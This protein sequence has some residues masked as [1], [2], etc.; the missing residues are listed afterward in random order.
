[1]S[2]GSHAPGRQAAAPDG[3]DLHALAAYLPRFIKGLQAPLEAELISGGKSNLTYYLRSGEQEWVLRRPPLGHV[4]PT[5]HDMKR[6]FRVISGLAGSGVPIPAALRLCEDVAVIGA[7]FYVMERAEGI[8]VHEELPSG[9]AERPEDRRAM[10]EAFIDTLARLHTVDYAAAGLADFGRP[11]GFMERQVRRWGEQWDRSKTRELPAIEE[12]RRRLFRSLP[13]SPAPGIVHGDYR[14]ENMI[15]DVERPGRIV[16]VLDWEMATLGDPLADLGYALM[17]WVEAGDSVERQQVMDRGAV[18]MAPGFMTR[19]EL[20]TRY[21]AVSGRT[22]R[23]VDFYTVFAHYKLAI[24]VEGI[25]ARFQ[26]GETRGEGFEGYDLKVPV[27]ADLG[28]EI[29]DRSENRALRGG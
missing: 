8:V 25:V 16:A 15:F 21:E 28:L 11:E 13:E 27:L 7:P 26:A 6:E 4:L 19:A 12:L 3:I 23:D 22:L 9:F 10:S 1:M 20:V 29:A 14:L 17:Y 2:S 24:I 18:S 5:A